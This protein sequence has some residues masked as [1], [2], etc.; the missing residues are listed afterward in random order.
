MQAV[1]YH[2]ISHS[3]IPPALLRRL[4]AL[5]LRPG[6]GR[7]R[8]RLRHGT[9]PGS[10]QR[11]RLVPPDLQQRRLGTNRRGG[12]DIKSA[13]R[14]QRPVDYPPA[15]LATKLRPR[16]P[17]QRRQPRQRGGRPAPGELLQLRPFR[18]Y[19]GSIPQRYKLCSR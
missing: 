16:R 6:V 2:A 4:A 17:P 3:L 19:Q 5:R 1:L 14:Q 13:P 10:A 8:C 15:P 7:H 9:T 18:Q 12:R 11:R